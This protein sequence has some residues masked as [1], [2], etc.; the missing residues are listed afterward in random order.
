MSRVVRLK[1]AVRIILATG[2]AGLLSLGGLW[3]L[4]TGSSRFP[5][6]PMAWEVGG[7]TAVAM[8][9]F[10]F[11]ALVADRICP[12]ADWRLAG[13]LLGVT[14]LAYVGGLLTLA[15]MLMGAIV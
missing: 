13:T 5:G 3:A 11:C 1:L 10:V 15:A 4:T 7:V 14:G 8:G 6:W 9:Q 12:H 2:W